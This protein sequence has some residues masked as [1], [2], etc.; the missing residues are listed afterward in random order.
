MSDHLDPIAARLVAAAAEQSRTVRPTQPAPKIRQVTL[1]PPGH[2]PITIEGSEVLGV[3][4]GIIAVKD[5]RGVGNWV[6]GGSLA[7]VLYDEPSALAAV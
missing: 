4:N 2:P 5:Y 3:G 1:Y 7:Y 6:L